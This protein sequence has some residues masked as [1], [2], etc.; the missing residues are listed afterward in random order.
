MTEE[1]QPQLSPK[2]EQ[3]LEAFLSELRP[4]P[5]TRKPRIRPRGEGYLDISVPTA[6]ENVQAAQASAEAATET[7]AEEVEE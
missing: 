7:A 5:F 1:L 3:E 4:S 2:D 6:V